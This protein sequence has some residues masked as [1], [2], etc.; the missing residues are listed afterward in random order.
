MVDLIKEK[1]DIIFKS[2]EKL[3]MKVGGLMWFGMGGYVPVTV[4]NAA[5]IACRP[6]C[7]NAQ[8]WKANA[9]QVVPTVYRTERL[10]Q[11]HH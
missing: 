10:S 1:M 6:H 2:S 9:I 7:Q 11:L 8:Y 5:Y 4:S 3:R